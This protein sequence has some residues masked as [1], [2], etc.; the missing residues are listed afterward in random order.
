[1]YDVWQNSQ[2]SLDVDFKDLK[3]ASQSDRCRACVACP[4][5]QYMWLEQGAN[6]R[7][8]PLLTRNTKGLVQPWLGTP[9]GVGEPISLWQ[10]F[11]EWVWGTETRFSRIPQVCLA[12]ASVE[13]RSYVNPGT[14]TPLGS[15]D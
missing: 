6:P 14:G 5:V 12:R 13:Q 7:R 4:R 8:M 1:M 3:G 11:P 2:S 10:I 9:A 15:E